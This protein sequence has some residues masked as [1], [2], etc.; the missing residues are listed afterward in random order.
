MKCGSPTSLKGLHFLL[1]A[2]PPFTV[3]PAT[4]SHP[5]ASRVCPQALQLSSSGLTTNDL[6]LLKS[7]SV[8]KVASSWN[9]PFG[10]SSHPRAISVSTLFF[11]AVSTHFSGLGAEDMCPAAVQSPSPPAAV[12]KRRVWS[13]GFRVH[14]RATPAW[15]IADKQE[16]NAYCMPCTGRQALHHRVPLQP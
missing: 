2:L 11:V 12:G 8:F 7:Y 10:V 5:G 13:W 14:G 15:H 6:C 3:P 9:F 16:I 1:P 4:S